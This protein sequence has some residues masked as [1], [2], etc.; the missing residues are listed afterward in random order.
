M[1]QGYLKLYRRTLESQVF[2]NEGLLKVWIWCLLKANHKKKWVTLK[3]GRGETEVEVLPGQFIFGRKAAAKEL[4]MKESTIRDR[5]KKLTNM[6]NLDTKPATHYTLI[7]IVNWHTYQ[8]V[9][10]K[11]DSKDDNQPTTN[12]QPTTTNKNDKNDKKTNYANLVTLTAKEYASLKEKFGEKDTAA[13]IKN[14]DGYKGSHGKKYNSDYLTILNWH[15]RAEA[16][17]KDKAD[18]TQKTKIY[19]A[20]PEG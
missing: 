10:K 17:K 15:R 14:L 16:E 20:F 7:T 19:T 8:P 3:T 12:R 6:R 9:E 18:T 4:K 13:K 1:E 11:A 2:Q 5:V